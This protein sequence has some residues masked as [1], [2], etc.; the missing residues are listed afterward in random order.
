MADSSTTVRA[1]GTVTLFTATVAEVLSSARQYTL[2]SRKVTTIT[3]LTTVSTSAVSAIP[4]SSSQQL[5]GQQLDDSQGGGNRHPLHRDH[6]WDAW[7]CLAVHWGDQEG[8]HR[9]QLHHHRQ[10]HRCQ[11]HRHRK[12][13][14]DGRQLDDSSQG[15]GIFTIFTATRLGMLGSAQQ[16]TLESRKVTTTTSLTTVSLIAV[17]TIAI[18]SSQQLDGLQ[19]DDSRQGG[20]GRHH[21]HHD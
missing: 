3:S 14:L 21:L 11:R 4:I 20:G 8:G 13:Q 12:Q 10:R 7:Q 16:Y 9:H 17:S 1:G 18:S 5:D 19:L 6:S 2:E 15:R